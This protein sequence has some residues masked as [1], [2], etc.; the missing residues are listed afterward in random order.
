MIVSECLYI[1][2]MNPPFLTGQGASFLFG[3]GSL[4]T[5]SGSNF[6]DSDDPFWRNEIVNTTNS[7]IC[8]NSL[9]QF[10][11]VAWIKWP[12][13]KYTEAGTLLCPSSSLFLLYSCM[14]AKNCPIIASRNK[15]KNTIER[16]LFF[17]SFFITGLLASSIPVF[18]VRLIHGV[19]QMFFF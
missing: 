5:S 6:F 11:N 19:R 12:E 1:F 7:A 10:S 8:K 2:N 15:V 14:P 13:V 16:L 4:S 18:A 17:Q 3:E 9:S